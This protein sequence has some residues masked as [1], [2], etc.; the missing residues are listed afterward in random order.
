MD[1]LRVILTNCEVTNARFVTNV[2]DVIR[3]NEQKDEALCPSFE[4]MQLVVEQ[5]V[6]Q[7]HQDI[8]QLRV[9]IQQATEQLQ[10][11]QRELRVDMQQA[12]E[13]Q[14]NTLE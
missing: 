12:V 10:E 1:D 9:D 11:Q 13:Q 6:H 2:N 14:Q 4:R 7:V 3:N 5:S 8:R